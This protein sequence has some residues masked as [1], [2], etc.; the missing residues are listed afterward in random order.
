MIANVD[1][2]KAALTMEELLAVWG[3]QLNR[4][5]RTTCPVHGGNDA[6]FSAKDGVGTCFSQCGGKTWTVTDL[7]MDVRNLTFPEALE[8]IAQQS[9]V[10][11]KYQG[12][13]DRTELIE[14]AKKERS[15]KEELYTVNE[16]VLEH[17]EGKREIQYSEQYDFDGRSW[18]GETIKAF[19][20]VQTPN[21]NVLTT[22]KGIQSEALRELG[23]I[24]HSEQKDIWYDF[25]RDRILFPIFTHQGRVA[26]FSG[27]KLKTAHAESPK[28][29]NSLESI[30]YKKRDL[31][32]GLWQNRRNIQ[33]EGAL[34]FEGMADV[35]TAYDHGV[36][37]A[38][39][40]G[41]TAVTK[42]QLQLLKRYTK[43]VT[44]LMDGDEAGYKAAINAVEE[45]IAIGLR[46]QVCFFKE[47]AAEDQE[48]GIDRYDPDNFLRK[49]GKEAFEAVLE[50]GSE[51]GL[52]WRVMQE[53]DS[54]DIFQQHAAVSLAA[55]LISMLG[56]DM[57][58]DYYQRE[59]CKK[60]YLGS[61]HKN[62]LADL[63]K[64]EHEKRLKD[65]N[66]PNLTSQQQSDI[67]KYGIYIKNNQYW[68]SGDEEIEGYPISNFSIHPVMLVVG[69]AKSERRVEIRNIYGNKFTANID[70]DSFVEMAAFRKEVER[71][72][73]FLFLETFR[74]EHFTKMK[75]KLYDEMK[76]CYPI[77]TLGRHKKMDFFAWANG[78]V[79][80]KFIPTDDH[81][82]VVFNDA[83]FFLPAFASAS[84]DILSDDQD[85]SYEEQKSF[86]YVPEVQAPSLKEW[87]AKMVDVH[88][89]KGMMAV[90]WYLAALY[91]DIIYDRMEFFPHL[92]CFGPPG[93]GK[94]FM[95]WSLSYMF[96][97]ARRPFN[98]H[99]G[100]NVGFFRRMA[101]VRNGIA[102]YDEY[103][104]SMDHRRAQG[105]KNAYDGAGREKGVASTDNRTVVTQ[106]NSALLIT[107]QEMPT[108]DI[109]LYTRCITMSFPE[110]KR[111]P[112]QNKKG[113][114]LVAIQ[115][116]GCLSQITTQMQQ[117]RGY[118]DDHFNQ[119][120]DEIRTEMAASVRDKDI[121]DRLI[122][123]YSIP[124]A[125]T[126][127]LKQKEDLGFKFNDLVEFAIRNLIWQN[128]SISQEDDLA[129]WWDT[130]EYFVEKK[131][132][133]HDEDILVQEIDSITIRDQGGKSTDTVS[134][135]FVGNKKVLFL[136]FTKS[137]R[138]Y[139][140]QLRREG[141]S[142]GLNKEA[143]RYYL[144]SSPA[145]IGEIRAKKFGGSAKRC[146]A[147]D[148]AKLKM[149]LPL[150]LH[151]GDEA[152]NGKPF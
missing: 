61:T 65:K 141:S 88:G 123:N 125:V 94:S 19:R 89:E 55:R 99:D 90:G 43:E 71:R 42:Q 129:V 18:T 47:P 25:L 17:F 32:Y 73:N 36:R 107:G 135:K 10:D 103:N 7:V 148:M 112:E 27:R 29:K 137:Y 50:E 41:G 121:L 72:G 63:L 68:I 128:D 83:K 95:G 143:V 11:I 86:I 69:S 100:T 116:T 105:L 6:N 131:E 82:I 8:Y 13:A 111:S 115:Q 140:E 3:H 138:F 132:L 114:E 80:D 64:E 2:I 51:D 4:Q 118:I 81:G 37:R 119:I 126:F 39:A 124:L 46:V 102:W 16:Q 85:N 23:L 139:K 35:V 57:L 26:G 113:D 109:A 152:D 149:D 30:V 76:V 1:E 44:I 120:Y 22:K 127:M 21:K 60:Q 106:V 144:K 33:Q 77:T 48:A 117:Y 56:N 12:N 62:S 147:F 110:T 122:N 98:L 130:V 49:Y 134:L 108:Q 28:Y 84:E 59:L 133:R 9:G 52:I 20:I 53:W 87:S 92:N 78:I 45:A 66:K 93:T 70:S 75:R 15:R 142:G 5:R 145:F 101:Q 150:S 91:R 96:G 34:L 97:K 24:R 146:Y 38:V 136:T 74:P 104:N 40:P 14:A 67:K 58:Q 79:A 151:F 31:L 54:K